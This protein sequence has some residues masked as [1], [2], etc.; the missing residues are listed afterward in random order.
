MAVFTWAE[1][2][3]RINRQKHGLSFSEITDVF[4]DPYLIEFYD[5]AHSGVGDERYICLGRWQDF[6]VL[7]V[8]FTEMDGDIHL[9]SAREATPREMHIY[10]ENYRRETGGN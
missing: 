9:I 8:V 5:K 4:D 10:E 1:W 6:T 2:K 3:D 7:S